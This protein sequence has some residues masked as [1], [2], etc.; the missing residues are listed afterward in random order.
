M[1]RAFSMVCTLCIFMM[2]VSLSACDDND[3]GSGIDGSTHLDALSESER[4]QFCE[5]MIQLWGGPGVQF[6]CSV[7]SGDNQSSVSSVDTLTIPAVEECVE[8]DQFL[9]HCTVGDAEACFTSTGGDPCLV[10]VTDECTAFNDCLN[11]RTGNNPPANDCSDQ[12]SDCYC[13]AG[14]YESG[15]APLGAVMT[16]ACWSWFV[17]DPCNC[18]ESWDECANDI[19]NKCTNT[20]SQCKNCP[21]GKCLCTVGHPKPW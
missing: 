13:S 15:Q 14:D 12:Y 20:I 3:T 5:W 4:T 1:G 2:L 18:Y 9:N 21:G 17:C 11:G 19:A 7:I 6:E 10:G 16:G 8:G